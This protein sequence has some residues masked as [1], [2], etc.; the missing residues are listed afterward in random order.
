MRN[1]TQHFYISSPTFSFNR[2]SFLSQEA[3]GGDRQKQE[4]FMRKVNPVWDDFNRAG[5]MVKCKWQ[6][7]RYWKSQMFKTQDFIFAQWLGK[8]GA[9]PEG[10]PASER[11]TKC[12]EPGDFQS[13]GHIQR[14]TSLLL[15]T[16][17]CWAGLW[18]RADKSFACFSFLLS[19]KTTLS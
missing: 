9:I 19:F 12:A 18:K 16:Q 11:G 8:K 13:T 1:E 7:V 6:E 10:R 17:F 14:T 15:S 3:S 4:E 5:I 2:R